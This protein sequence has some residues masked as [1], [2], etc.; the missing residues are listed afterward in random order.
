MTESREF[1]E[2]VQGLLRGDFSRSEPLFEGDPCP[3]LAWAQGMT[4]IVSYRDLEAWQLGMSFVEEVYALTRSFP[5]EELFG[6]TF[7]LRRAAV[8]IPSLVAEGHQQSTKTYRNY[9]IRAL[10]SQAECETQMELALRLAFAPPDRL[11]PVSLL[12]SRVGQVLHGL[13]RSLPE[14]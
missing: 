6:L 4:K 5:R 10:G 2:A 1:R 8:S 12:L 9:V 7:Q 3:I 13:V 14:T 11:R